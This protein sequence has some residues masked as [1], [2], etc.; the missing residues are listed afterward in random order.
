MRTSAYT[1]EDYKGSERRR[2]IMG[3]LAGEAT[4][5]AE[6]KCSGG[7]VVQQGQ[8]K[9]RYGNMEMVAAET[10]D[11]RDGNSRIAGQHRWQFWMSVME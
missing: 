11:V 1:R 5:T 3:Q 9:C 7:D 2:R 6:A 10:R 4:Q 8:Q